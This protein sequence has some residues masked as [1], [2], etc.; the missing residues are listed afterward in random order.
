M[1][2]T[3][4]LGSMP[5]EMPPPIRYVDDG[6]DPPDIEPGMA[7]PTADGRYRHFDDDMVEDEYR[8]T[9]FGLALQQTNGHIDDLGE[10]L[11]RT[12]LVFDLRETLK[13]DASG[14]HLAKVY[15]FGFATGGNKDYGALSLDL[16]YGVRGG[17]KALG[18]HQL[19]GQVEGT[20]NAMFLHGSGVG[21]DGGSLGVGGKVELGIGIQYGKDDTRKL[22]ISVFS[23]L[24][25]NRSET[26]ISL[27]LSG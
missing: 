11:M 10:D 25:T 9:R 3:A 19:Y 8:A 5:P 27:R 1:K 4:P 7:K 22:E 6:G 2:D 21:S 14:D 24:A 15:E 23:E 16:G 17:V 18:H 13:G 20:A 12:H 26:G